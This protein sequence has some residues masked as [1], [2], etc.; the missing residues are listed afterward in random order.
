M[1]VLIETGK[2]CDLVHA[3]GWIWQLEFLTSK[4]RDK[5]NEWKEFGEVNWMTLASVG[6][7][8]TIIHDDVNGRFVVA[9]TGPEGIR[10]H[11]DRLVGE[12]GSPLEAMRLARQDHRAVLAKIKLMEEPHGIVTNQEDY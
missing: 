6:E 9:A 3:F 12:T 2:E 8:Y 10:H 4:Y 5:N 1:S 11:W 7:T